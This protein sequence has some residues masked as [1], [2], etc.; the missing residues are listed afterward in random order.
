MFSTLSGQCIL[1]FVDVFNPL[2]ATVFD[3][4]GT[5]SVHVA[6]TAATTIVTTCLPLCALQLCILEPFSR[7][8]KHLPEHP[9]APDCPWQCFEPLGPFV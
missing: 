4:L 5:K 2:A 1:V 9:R 8:F 6:I 7:D 3:S